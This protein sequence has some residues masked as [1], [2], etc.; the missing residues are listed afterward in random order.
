MARKRSTFSPE[1]KMQVVFEAM[2]TPLTLQQ[3][4]DKHQISVKNI[5]N[6][7]QQFFEKAH[8]SFDN[9]SSKETLASL[10][11]EN[12]ALEKRLNQLQIEHDFVTQK[13]KELDL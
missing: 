4:A 9:P 2:Q 5:M 11:K 3:L 10:K 7:K 6:W 8:L 13:L 12:A 1:F